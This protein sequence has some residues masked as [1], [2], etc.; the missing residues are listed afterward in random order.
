MEADAEVP[1]THHQLQDLIQREAAKIAN[2]R[3]QQEVTA[4]RKAGKKQSEGPHIQGRRTT[5]KENSKWKERKKRHGRKRGQRLSQQNQQSLGRR[6]RLER[7]FQQSQQP[8]QPKIATL[9][10]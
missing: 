9:T 10:Q 7:C 4:L 6:E 1:A 3:I 5:K 8:Q 2:K